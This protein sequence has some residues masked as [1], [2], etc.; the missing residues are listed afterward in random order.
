MAE[1]REWFLYIIRCKGNTL[2]TGITVDVKKRFMEHCAGKGAKY[3]KGRGPLTIEYI[4]RCETHSSAL[5]REYEIK[6]YTRSE[7]EAL[8]ST[9]ENQKTITEFNI[10][11]S[12]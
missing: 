3:T 8:I 5:K 12:V 2:Y 11:E 4:E 7:K 1:K 9:A 6:H 10:L